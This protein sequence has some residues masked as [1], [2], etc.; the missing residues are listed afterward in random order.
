[1]DLLTELRAGTFV[2]LSPEVGH[3]PSGI[4][5]R[6]V[7][8]WDQEHAG[9]ELEADQKVFPRDGQAADV[10][11]NWVSAEAGAAEAA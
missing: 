5:R 9:L 1:V 10:Y 7:K 11:L 2:I 6:L 3:A 4:V 8:L